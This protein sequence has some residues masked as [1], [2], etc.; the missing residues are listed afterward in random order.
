MGSNV[1]QILQPLDRLKYNKGE[2]VLNN[3][4]KQCME[5]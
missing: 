3:A 4:M 1:T 5:T 2:C